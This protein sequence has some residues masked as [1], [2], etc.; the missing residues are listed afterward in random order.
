MRFLIVF[1]Y[2]MGIK[3]YGLMVCNVMYH[4]RPRAVT[5]FNA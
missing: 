4:Y 1:S 5:P 3:V 2:S